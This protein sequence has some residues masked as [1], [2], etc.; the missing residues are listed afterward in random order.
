MVFG[1]IDCRIHIYYQYKKNG[2]IKTVHEI[3]DETV[4]HYGSVL[5]RL[6]SL[7][8]NFVV[9]GVP[10]ATRVRNEYRYP[11]YAPPEIHCRINSMFNE[12]LKEFCIRNGYHYIDMYSRFSDTDGFMLKAYAADE[13]HLNGRVAYF[14]KGELKSKLGLNI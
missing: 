7:G 9:Q 13:I 8:I 3:I 10:P 2:E 1:E 12:K 6:Q 11:F 5:G 4:S 14:V